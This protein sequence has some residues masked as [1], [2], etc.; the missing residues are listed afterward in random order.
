MSCYSWNDRWLSCLWLN[1]Y[2]NLDT[3]AFVHL[4]KATHNLWYSF[5]PIQW[6]IQV[7]TV[8]SLCHRNH[9]ALNILIRANFLID[10]F[11]KPFLM[12]EVAIFSVG[13]ICVFICRAMNSA[14]ITSPSPL[15]P[16]CPFSSSWFMA[17]SFGT[18]WVMW[19]F[20]DA[21]A[22]FRMIVLF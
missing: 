17:D 18:V 21:L 5:N 20:L 8:L 6:V 2:Y 19:N 16:L 13:V 7:I 3:R 12:Y 15:F 11:F 1:I 10:L 14:R 4:S 9:I 22:K